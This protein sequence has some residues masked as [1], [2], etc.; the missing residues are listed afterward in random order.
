MN[1]G[2]FAH[3]AAGVAITILVDNYSNAIL[4]GRGGVE[5]MDQHEEVP[6][7]EHGFSALIELEGREGAILVD[8]GYTP[9]AL[10]HNLEAMKI[11]P[12][13][14]DQ[15]V[16]SHGHAD[17]AAAMVPMLR[18][19]GGETPVWVAPGAFRERWTVAK[20]GQ[21]I[22]PRRMPRGE[23]EAAGARV[24]VAEGPTMLA[25]GCWLTGPVPRRT[26][27]EKG[28]P[29]ACFR[30]G[31][32]LVHDEVPDDQSVVVNV[33]G[34]GLVV[35]SGC[36]HAGIVN[37]LRYAREITGVDRLRAV[38]GGFHLT[39]APGGLIERTVEEVKAMEPELVSPMH[40]T[41]FEATA[42]FA[43]EM[44]GAFVLN[45]VGTRYRF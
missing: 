20:D 1:E 3:E 6:L 41:G 29:S 17:H 45:S 33:T 2:R 32:D 36:S 42:L 10:L 43:G 26:D 15:V 16:V 11:D 35:L 37:I 4:K 7:A 27:F 38:L 8:A 13:R 23:W 18:A 44:P 24:Q 14:I 5:R 39:G 34:Q 22:G 25:D 21:R 40:C 30:Q 12:R 31:D 9:Q 19:L 28:V